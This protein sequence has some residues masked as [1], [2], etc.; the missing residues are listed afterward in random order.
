MSHFSLISYLLPLFIITSH[1]PPLLIITSYAG[2][3]GLGLYCLSKRMDALGGGYGVHDR[4][5]GTYM[6]GLTPYYVRINAHVHLIVHFQCIQ[7][8]MYLYLRIWVPFFIFYAFVLFTF[9]QANKGL[10]FGFHFL[11]DRTLC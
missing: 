7:Y 11:I 9:Q 6:H 1:L 2:G 4:K 10:L 8:Y 5:D 3:T